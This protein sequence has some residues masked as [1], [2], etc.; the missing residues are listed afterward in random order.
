M[1][2]YSHITDIRTK[3]IIDLTVCHVYMLEAEV[4]KIYRPKSEGIRGMDQSWFCF[5][6]VSNLR[7]EWFK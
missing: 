4:M 5:C 7:E 1:I 3:E 2:I 6:A